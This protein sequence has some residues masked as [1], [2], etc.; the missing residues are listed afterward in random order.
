VGRSPG[1]PARLARESASGS[2]RAVAGVPLSPPRADQGPDV[3]PPTDRTRTAWP[4]WR[5]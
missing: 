4:R 5:G 3:R 2:R 1:A